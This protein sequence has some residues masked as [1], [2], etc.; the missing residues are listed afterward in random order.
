LT[1]IDLVPDHLAGE[2]AEAAA[3][4]LGVAGEQIVP[5]C[6]RWGTL[7]NLGDVVAAIDDALPRAERLKASRCIRQIR[8]EQDE[9]KIVRQV[10]NGLR[11]TGGWAVGK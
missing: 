2:A 11:L 4:D 9:D 8:K 6:S 5:V 1:H 3:A 10:L 7:T